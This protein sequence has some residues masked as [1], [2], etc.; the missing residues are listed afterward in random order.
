M[1][2]SSQDSDATLNLGTP[3]TIKDRELEL[4][5]IAPIQTLKRGNKKCGK[6]EGFRLFRDSADDV[7]EKFWQT[8]GI[9]D[10]KSVY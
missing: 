7:T 9:V 8:F 4:I 10:S 3:S 2:S 6:E 1:T 5:I